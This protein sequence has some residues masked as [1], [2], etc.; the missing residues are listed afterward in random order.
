MKHLIRKLCGKVTPSEI[1][2]WPQEKQARLDIGILGSKYCTSIY[3]RSND[4]VN[5]KP[6]KFFDG[7]LV[8]FNDENSSD[9]YTVITKD[10]KY[11]LVKHMITEM[12]IRICLRDII[13]S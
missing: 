7:I 9:T 12:T 8:W 2:I 5:G 13:L 10:A 1:R 4:I 11:I 3:M 6:E